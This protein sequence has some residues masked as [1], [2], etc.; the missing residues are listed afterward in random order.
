MHRSIRHHHALCRSLSSSASLPEQSINN[1]TS[2]SGTRVTSNTIFYRAELSSYHRTSLT[3]VRHLASIW[4]HTPATS[5]STST[6]HSPR[7]VH[8]CHSTAWGITTS[9]DTRLPELLMYYFFCCSSTK[10][11]NVIERARSRIKTA[12]RRSTS[13]EPAATT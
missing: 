11:S 1:N 2:K 7:Y 12:V 9:Q 4:H 13:T 8:K 5:Q 6:G 3:A 10:Y